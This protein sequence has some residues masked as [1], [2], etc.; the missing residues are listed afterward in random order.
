MFIRHFD[1]PDE[2]MGA[3]IMLELLHTHSRVHSPYRLL[4][5]VSLL[6]P[7]PLPHIVQV[8]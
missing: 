1:V 4:S 7:I 2:L 6:P 5:Y 3:S 8:H